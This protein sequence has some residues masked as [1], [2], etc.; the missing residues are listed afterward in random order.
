M[1]TTRTLRPMVRRSGGARFRHAASAAFGLAL[2]AFVAPARAENVPAPTAWRI[3]L[4][5]QAQSTI[6]EPLVDPAEALARS[7]GRLL[8]VGFH[9]TE[10]GH[11]GVKALKAE[12]AAGNVGGVLLMGRNIRGRKQVRRLVSAL[13]AAAP[14]G[15]LAVLIDQEG[16]RVARVNARNGFH[17]IPSAK[18]VSRMSADKAA[19]VFATMAADLADIGVAANLA[20]VVDLALEPR[21]GVIARAGRSYGAD[22]DA[23]TGLA[24]SFLEAHQAVGVGSCLKHFPGHG[25]VK[26]DTHKG[27]VNA[28]GRWKPKLELAPYRRLAAW[29]APIRAGCVMTSHLYVPELAGPEDE[30]V[31]FSRRALDLLRWEIGFDGVAITDDLLMGAATA[32]KSFGDAAVAALGA[33]HD[34]ILVTDWRMNGPDAPERMRAAVRKAQ[35]DGRLTRWRVEDARWRVERW[36]D[37]AP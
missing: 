4:E 30:I 17:T 23:V 37:R 27:P 18:R 3:A 35:S 9:G 7:V 21:S 25:S 22:P 26:G 6:S 36:L 14:D 13:R 33:G 32:S 19:S 28:A 10:P 15:R 1:R 12:I 20:P 8:V 29:D 11:R 31:T 2:F 34:M 5:T 16:G 24:T